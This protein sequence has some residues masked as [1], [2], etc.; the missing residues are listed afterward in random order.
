MQMRVYVVMGNDYPNGVY[1]SEREAQAFC[2]AQP[3][4]KPPHIYWRVYPFDLIPA[5]PVIVQGR[6]RRTTEGNAAT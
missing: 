1:A 5:S 4:D 3:K 6:M 2:D